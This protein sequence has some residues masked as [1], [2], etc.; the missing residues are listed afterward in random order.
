MKVQG[1]AQNTEQFKAASLNADL[2]YLRRL[3]DTINQKLDQLDFEIG[4]VAYRITVQDKAVAPMVPSNNK[5]LKYMAAAPV[6]VLFLML[7]VF[8]LLEVRPSGSPTPTRCP[9]GCSRRSMPCRRCRRP[10]RSEAG[11]RR[12]PT[13]RS[14][15]SSSGSTTCGSPSAAARPSWR[16]AG[17]C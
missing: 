15:S 1:T 9:R 16:R 11:R 13:T 5:R 10:G 3:R 14:S 7:G 6:G 17:A 4:Q 12:T 8:L 2:A